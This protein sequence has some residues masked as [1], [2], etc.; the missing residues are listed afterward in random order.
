MVEKPKTKTR[1]GPGAVFLQCTT[2]DA[3]GGLQVGHGRWQL[4][5][6]HS[7]GLQVVWFEFCRVELLYLALL[8]A[9]GLLV[10][11]EA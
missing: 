10:Q 8:A 9:R 5:T 4:R 2:T 3:T 6:Y 11:R 7:S 1:T